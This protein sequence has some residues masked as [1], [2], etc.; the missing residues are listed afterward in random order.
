MLNKKY[1]IIVLILK[2][3]ILNCE[4]PFRLQCNNSV[5]HD[6]LQNLCIMQYIVSTKITTLS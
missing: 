2:Y 4:I 1:S 6:I 5:A 3:E